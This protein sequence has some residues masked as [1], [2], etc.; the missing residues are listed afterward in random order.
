MDHPCTDRVV[1]RDQTFAIW[2]TKVCHVANVALPHMHKEG[3]KVGGDSPGK[4]EPAE[5]RAL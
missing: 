5:K 1:M 4:K 2:H 3:V